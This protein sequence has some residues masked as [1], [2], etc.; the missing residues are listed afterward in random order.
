MSSEHTIPPALIATFFLAPALNVSLDLEP[1]QHTQFFHPKFDLPDWPLLRLST[2]HP[3]DYLTHT[4]TFGLPRSPAL[5]D[6]AAHSTALADMLHMSSM[7]QNMIVEEQAGS[8]NTT[9]RGPKL[10]TRSWVTMAREKPVYDHAAF[11]TSMFKA[12]VHQVSERL[13]SSSS[14]Y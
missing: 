12:D 4:P 13:L 10:Q 1:T 7:W 2:S 6:Y 9:R 8:G 3:S 11:L 5:E 14:G